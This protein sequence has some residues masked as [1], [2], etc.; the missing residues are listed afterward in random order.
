[1]TAKTEKDKASQQQLIKKWKAEI[2]EKF[3]ICV[4]LSKRISD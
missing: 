1:M 2:S 3:P 4:V